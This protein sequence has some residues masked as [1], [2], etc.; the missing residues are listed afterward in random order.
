MNIWMDDRGTVVSAGGSSIPCD[1]PPRSAPGTPIGVCQDVIYTSISAVVTETREPIKIMFVC[2]G[3]I[4]RSPLAEGVFKEKVKKRGLESYFEI[5]SSGTGNWHVGKGADTRMVGTA[6]RRG[7]SLDS[8]VAQ[9]FAANDFESYDLIL[10]MDKSNL[11][12]V[13]YLDDDNEWGDRVKLFRE[14][15]PEPEDYQVPDPYYGGPEGFD[16]VYEIVDRTSD[17]LLGSLVAH[18]DLPVEA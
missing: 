17:R 18:F 15:D 7:V 8:H 9:Q 13:L 10:V 11:H 16:H 12:D 6:K 2:L 4:C 5:H 1:L 3:N 14:F